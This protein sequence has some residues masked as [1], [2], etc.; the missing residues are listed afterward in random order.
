MKLKTVSCTQ[1]AGIRDRQIDFTDGVNVICGSNESGKT[2]LVNLLSRT[3]F[4]S[5]KLDHRTDKGFQEQFFPAALQTGAPAGDFADGKVTFETQRGSFTLQKEWG[6]DAR[7]TLSTPDGILRDAGSIETMLRQEMGYG[8]GVYGQMLF[9]TRR[10]SDLTLQE[11]VDAAAKSNA[12]QELLQAL[13]RAFSQTDGMSANAIEA[14]VEAKL[15]E[16]AGKHWDMENRRPVRKT[17]RWSTGLGRILKSW[18]VLEDARQLMQDLSELEDDAATTY[19]AFLTADAEAKEKEAAAE[20]FRNFETKLTVHAQR[21]SQ[22]QRLGEDLERMTQM[23]DLWPVQKAELDA[24]VA[25]RI[26]R[27]RCERFNKYQAAREVSVELANLQAHGEGPVPTQTDV[28]RV[29]KLQQKI[30]RLE[31]SLQAMNLQAVVK[32]L[33]DHEAEIRTVRN[34]ALL[35]LTQDTCAITEAVT[36]TVPGIMELRLQPADVDAEAVGMELSSLREQLAEAFRHF[37]ARTVSEL[38]TMVQE[39]QLRQQT[40]ER[41]QHKLALVLA[42][43]DLEELTAAVERDPAPTRDLAQIDRDL[44]LLCGTVPAEKFITVRETVLESNIRQYGSPE[45][46]GTQ[47]KD[48]SRQYED[49][50]VSEGDLSDIPE[51][52]RTVE[53]P[54]AYRQGLEQAAQA[55]RQMRELALNARIAA[56]ERLESRRAGLTEDPLQ[57][58]EDAKREFEETEALL[59]HWHHIRQVF[60]AQKEAADHSPIDGL[61]DS[62]SQYLRLLSGGGVSSEFPRGDRLDMHISSRNRVLDYAKLSEGTKGTVSLA[63]RLAV[64]DQLFPDGGVIVLD[65]PFADMDLERTEQACSLIRACS[66]KHQIIVLTCREMYLPMLGGNQIRL[67]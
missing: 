25:L 60:A 31:G 12:R 39:E 28:E 42:G 35:D 7:C 19:A 59:N 61:A 20:Q 65:D 36:V 5:A 56:A 38:E 34:N 10:G 54:E 52:Y 2:T 30:T 64:L 21:E 55:A 29:K 67:S 45:Q 18:Y 11:V 27:Q 46:L 40:M 33:G 6:P 23:L 26:E 66:E 8:E 22:L 51:E 14:A 63:F 43:A 15:E 24:A 41:L 9:S 58:L 17:G 4:Q 37:S 57:L 53:D 1:F 47:L 49:I 48:L 50:K 44:L 62:F 13:S 3:L 16:I 32:M